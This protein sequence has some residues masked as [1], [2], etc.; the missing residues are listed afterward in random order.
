MRNLTPSPHNGNGSVLITPTGAERMSLMRKDLH[1][2]EAQVIPDLL[3]QV[4]DLTLALKGLVA[5]SGD[6]SRDNREEALMAAERALAK[7]T[8]RPRATE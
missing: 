6:V 2:Y 7:P 1:R 3:E 8:S 5:A 4:R